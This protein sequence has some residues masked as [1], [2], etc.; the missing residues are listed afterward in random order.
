MAR[1]SVGS[2]ERALKA[3]GFA[4]QLLPHEMACVRP[5][6][7]EDLYERIEIVPVGSGDTVVINAAVSVVRCARA[8][9]RGLVVPGGLEELCT[10]PENGRV[11]LESEVAVHDWLERLERIAPSRSRELALRAGPTLLASTSQ[12]RTTARRAMQELAPDLPREALVAALSEP[13]RKRYEWLLHQQFVVGSEELRDEYEWAVAA[14]SV[15]GA[16]DSLATDAAFWPIRLVVDRRL[17][18][19]C[20]PTR[21]SGRFSAP[22]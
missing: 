16:L 2:I 9:F 8:Q 20:N 4:M 17:G 21:G 12:A 14:L 6:P 22:C 3:A 10:D 11:S 1:V 18:G 19:D 7:L 13:Q 15:L 5:A